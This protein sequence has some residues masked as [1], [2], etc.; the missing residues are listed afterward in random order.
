MLELSFLDIYFKRIFVY[1]IFYC[2]VSSITRDRNLTD[3]NP[4]N[5]ETTNNAFDSYQEV[6]SF[7]SGRNRKLNQDLQQKLVNV[8]AIPMLN[9]YTLGMVV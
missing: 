2:T 5:E 8:N 4:I 1:R 7:C 9:T 3:L 6:I